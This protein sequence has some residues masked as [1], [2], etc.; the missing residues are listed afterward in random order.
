[1]ASKLSLRIP[2]VIHRAAKQEAAFI[3]TSL[4]GL[5]RDILFGKPKPPKFLVAVRAVA[6]SP[7][8]RPSLLLD[9]KQEASLTRKANGDT[10]AAIAS[11]IISRFFMRKETK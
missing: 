10:P 3:G 9:E 2:R 1:M 7:L 8:M 4:T 6:T 11:D 5:L